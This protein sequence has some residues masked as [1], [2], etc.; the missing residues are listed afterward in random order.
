MIV[1]IIIQAED[2]YK[3]ELAYNT[4]EWLQKNPAASVQVYYTFTDANG[5]DQKRHLNSTQINGTHDYDSLYDRLTYEHVEKVKTGQISDTSVPLE[6]LRRYHVAVLPNLYIGDTN[7][8]DTAYA[9]AKG[10]N[11]N[12][13]SRDQRGTKGGDFYSCYYYYPWNTY[14]VLLNTG[15]AGEEYA[16]KLAEAYTET[17]HYSC[18]VE[19]G[20]GEIEWNTGTNTVTIHAKKDVDG[21]L[22][23]FAIYKNGDVLDIP[24]TTN[25]DEQSVVHCT[26]LAGISVDDFADLFDVTYEIDEIAGE[27]R[28]FK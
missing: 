9:A 11:L 16:H 14:V 25:T 18:H 27:V 4:A 24:Y 2:I 7:V 21:S 28:F 17:L 23:F 10:Q 8:S 5:N 6:Q 22:S 3:E 13:N 12:N 1:K 15:L 20:K 26:Y 19:Y